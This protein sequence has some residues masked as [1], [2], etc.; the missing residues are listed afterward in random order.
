MSA[1]SAEKPVKKKRPKDLK[2]A[3][4]LVATQKKAALS[5]SA[6]AVKAKLLVRASR[7]A[8]TVS[9][10]SP[11]PAPR[12]PVLSEDANIPESA[13]EKS[14][15]RRTPPRP[16][17]T[18]PISQNTSGG[19]VCR[20]FVK[21]PF[22]AVFWHYGPPGKLAHGEVRSPMHFRY[23]WE[24]KLFGWQM[25]KDIPKPTDFPDIKE[26]DAMCAG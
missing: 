16:I 1:Q 20:S 12:R 6:E 23:L 10:T 21:F 24:N 7:P 9:R 5:T 22:I 2:V 13:R 8:P 4:R 18:V 17:A 3:K 25:R 11:R 14:A 19:S 26:V 15:V